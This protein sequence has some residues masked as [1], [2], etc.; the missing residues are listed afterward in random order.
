MSSV[1]DMGGVADDAGR[2]FA[3]DLPPV[4]V[5][6]AARS[7]TTWVY[8]V[9]AAHPHVAGVL[10]SFLFTKGRG[11][12]GLMNLLDRPGTPDGMRSTIPTEEL[13]G[14]LRWFAAGLLGR[15]VEPGR[16]M[17]VEK[18]GVHAQSMHGIWRLFPDAR[19][20]HVL[21]DG[22]DVV[23]SALAAHR[24]WAPTWPRSTL[25][26]TRQWV[27]NALAAT[28]GRAARPDQFL[29]IRYEDLHADPVAGY[30]VLYDFCGLQYDDDLLAEVVDHNDFARQYAGGE[31]RFRRG[32]RV[33]DWRTRFSRADVA[34]F[35]VAGGRSLVRLGY[36]PDHRWVIRALA[37]GRASGGSR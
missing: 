19:F 26:A 24:S 20:V 22:R 35:F 30:R 14:E 12:G 13:A 1:T 3:L 29:E 37:L 25:R 18:S 32:A 27:A 11:I 36:E 6:G 23:V 7:G 15:S 28:H 34:Q 9:L 31:D 33:G 10:E 5:V 2:F 17:V 16:R 4:F 8:D 21:R